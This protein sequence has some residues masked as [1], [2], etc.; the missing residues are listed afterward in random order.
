MG[1]DAKA[2]RIIRFAAALWHGDRGRRGSVEAYLAEAKQIVDA[3]PGL[4][5]EA[6]GALPPRPTPAVRKRLGE[7]GRGTARRSDKAEGTL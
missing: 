7:H 2:N 4:D 5:R 3:L 6:V 1:A